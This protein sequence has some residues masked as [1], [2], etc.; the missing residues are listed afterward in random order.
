[1]LIEPRG[2]EDAEGIGDEAN[3]VI[4]ASP[5]RPVSP[6]LTSPG[7]VLGT[8]G[9]MSP[10]QAQGKTDQ[11]DHRSDIFA[12]GCILFEVVTGHKAFHGKDNIDILNKITRQPIPPISDFRSDGPTH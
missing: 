12:F 2:V 7:T 5:R 10:E 1:K 4:A 11:I 9:Y 8:V 6:S 3:A